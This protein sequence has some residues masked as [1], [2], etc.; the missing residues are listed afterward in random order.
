MT[1]KTNQLRC[2]VTM[3]LLVAAM[4]MPAQGNAKVTLTYDSSSSGYKGET[5]SNL[6]DGNTSTKWCFLAPLTSESA[7]VVFKAS[8]KCRLKGYTITTA[9]DNVSLTGRNPKDWIIYGSNDKSEWTKLD[10]VSNDTV[11][12]D[13]N[14]TPYEYTLATAI[15]TKYEYYKW[16]ITAN[17]GGALLRVSEFSITVC[18]CTETEHEGTLLLKKQRA[19]TCMEVATLRISISATDVEDATAMLSAPMQSTLR[20]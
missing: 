15:D 14:L 18:Q 9:N 20:L 8:Q 4:I 3:L 1:R 19:A 17:K 11:L 12:Q 2:L 6:F 5:A 13:Q 10:S 16:E 7:W